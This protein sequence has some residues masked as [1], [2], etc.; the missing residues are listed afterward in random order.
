MNNEVERIRLLADL[1][2]RLSESPVTILLGARQTGKTTLAR[3]AARKRDIVRFFDLEVAADRTA[4]A[5]TPEKILSEITGLVVLDEVQRVPSLFEI[6]RPLADRPDV[7]A[8]FL[9]LG[10]ASP[11]L[12]RTTSETLAGRALVLHIPGFMLEEV[13]VER[14]ND[15][16][17]RGAFPR[18]FLAD[19]EAASLRWR[20][21]F[22]DTFLERDIP[23]LGIR[24]PAETLRR[25]W[26]MLSHF[27]GQIWN[28]SELA[29]SLAANE[30]TARHYLDIL[31]GA[32]MIRVLPAW[33]ENIGKRQVKSSKV[34]IRDSGLLHALLG[35]STRAQL[36][37]HPRYGASWE[38]FALE[39][40]LSRFGD[41]HAW[42]WA[43]QRGAEL[44]LMV[45]YEGRRIGFEFKCADAPGMTRSLGIALTDLKLDRAFVVYPGATRYPL[46]DRVEAIPLAE[47]PTLKP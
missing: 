13:G 45:L 20:E 17:L 6:L 5:A 39:Q 38:G 8:R 9:L 47:I 23:K 7:P 34:Y 36:E 33:H 26:N 18:S 3:M 28:A 42:F 11:D 12:V 25:F 44:D 29:R 21:S 41:R 4:L 19:D 22:I 16:W 14:Q 2:I 15:L 10:S 35:I 1:N 30:K 40:T 37:S 31:A 32:Y 46:A 27:H 43:T 24:T